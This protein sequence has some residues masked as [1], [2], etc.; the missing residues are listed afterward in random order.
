L[1]QLIENDEQLSRVVKKLEGQPRVS[2]D[3]EFDRDRHTYG[4]DLCLVQVGFENECLI[5]DPLAVQSL[6]PLFDFFEKPAIQKLVHCPG[7]DLRLLH[8]LGC[9]PKNIAD[10]E[11]IAKLLN[12]EQTSLAK[13]L[14]LK[15]G[16]ILN[17]KQ[18][19]S[20]WHLRPLHE[21]QLKY[22]ADDVLYL[23]GLYDILYAEAVQKGIE[24]WV[25]E[26]QHW[27]QTV[28]YTLEKKT[29]FLKP[30]DKKNLSPWHA[31]VLNEI[32][33]LRDRIGEKKNKPAY[34]I[35]PE[36]SVRALAEGSP[37]FHLQNL[38]GLHPSLRHGSAAA[39]LKDNILAIFSTANKNGLSRR[40]ARQ[41]FSDEEREQYLL[42]KNRQKWLK[43]HFWAPIQQKMAEKLGS[44]AARYILSNGWITKWMNGELCWKDFQ[45]AYKQELVKTYAADL[46]LNY[47]EIEA[48]EQEFTQIAS[49]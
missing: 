15:C 47:R 40:A 35:M 33:V 20:N 26:E 45:P 37:E 27:L 10:T 24:G 19:Q 42:Q 28:K 48:Y 46:K 31:F 39:E 16:I 14:E 44:F 34:M 29:D 43:D 5:I 11:V 36:D 30:G 3:L 9:Y 4:F 17:K 49:E 8:H 6:K 7:E 38:Q 25:E 1:F 13:L 41:F 12:Y 32:F 21:D 2:F 22:A 18:Q 23:P